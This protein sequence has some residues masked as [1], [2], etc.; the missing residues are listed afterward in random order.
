MA[1][2]RQCLA[3][4]DGDE[5]RH[6]GRLLVELLA[7][8][9]AAPEAYECQGDSSAE[10]YSLFRKQRIVHI[11][12]GK[13][14]LEKDGRKTDNHIRGSMTVAVIDIQQFLQVIHLVVNLVILL[15]LFH[16][17]GA[18]YLEIEGECLRS[19]FLKTVASTDCPLLPVLTIHNLLPE[20]DIFRLHG[21]GEA[22]AVFCAELPVGI[23]CQ[24][25]LFHIF[26]L[27]FFLVS[28]TCRLS[29]NK[30]SSITF[31]LMC[32]Y[33]SSVI[34]AGR[35]TFFSTEVRTCI[36]FI[37]MGITLSFPVP[38]I[39]VSMS[40]QQSYSVTNPTDSAAI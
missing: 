29:C 25:K 35:T 40:L 4:L 33:T 30:S 13:L 9:L 3:L 37:I 26:Y 23:G 27:S 15:C 39:S 12:P 14:S 2:V 11:H 10:R 18:I 38:C 19:V 6:V 24:F 16:N 36:S 28:D 5:P 21:N 20:P 1:E 32:S 8:F 7:L 31:S 17:T 22:V 34:S